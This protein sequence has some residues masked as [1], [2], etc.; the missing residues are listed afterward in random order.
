MESEVF[1]FMISSQFSVFLAS[2]NI[3]K[4]G[5]GPIQMNI[6]QLSTD[7][8]V[9]SSHLSLF[10]SVFQHENAFRDTWISEK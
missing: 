10:L 7:L 5:A 4:H 6:Y 9:F 8:N 3:P 1:Y 2:L